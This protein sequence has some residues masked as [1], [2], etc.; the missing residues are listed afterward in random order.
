MRQLLEEVYCDECPRTAYDDLGRQEQWEYEAG[1]TNR[2]MIGRLSELGWY[3]D[4]HQDLC[5]RCKAE[6]TV[7][8][9]EVRADLASMQHRQ[10]WCE[11]DAST[12][13]MPGDTVECIE[14]RTYDGY[15]PGLGYR[16]HYVVEKVILYLGRSSI[17]L[18][19]V[20]HEPGYPAC[21][22]KLVE[23]GQ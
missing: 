18:E 16:R 5:P 22:F 23:E 12:P 9:E 13:F 10:Q 21:R 4:A 1:K 3:V 20:D 14:H 19:G 8:V 17:V 15:T 7:M 2:T 6:R 11:R